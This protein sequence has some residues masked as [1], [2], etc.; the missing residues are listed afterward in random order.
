MK[1]VEF[2]M[3]SILDRFKKSWNAF[4]GRDPTDGMSLYDLGP[5]T[6]YRPDRTRFYTL[7]VNRSIVSTI[8]NRIAV[9]CSMINI[10]HVK[11]NDEG[12]YQ[13]TINSTLN[14]CLTMNANIDQ[15]GRMF[16]QDAIMSMFDEGCVA[17]TPINTS[18]NPRN[19]ES[20]KIYDLRVGKIVEWYPKDVRIRVYNE[21]T[22]Q[23]EEKI[24]PKSAV[25]IVEN[26][27][28]S[29]MNE[30]NSLAQRLIRTLGQIDRINEQGAA[31]KM[32]IIIQLPYALKGDAKKAQAENRRKLLE[33]QLTNS[34]YGIGYIDQTEKIVQLNRSL[35]N[36][37]WTQAE[38]LRKQLYNQFGLTENIFN[39]TASE[40]E[41]LYYY[42]TTIDPI[43]SALSNA[44]EWKFLSKTAR[45]QG[46]A[47]RYY[48]DPFR[49]VPV[50]ELAEIADKFTRN[51]IMSSN[52][53]RS[54]IGLH[55]SEDPRAD[56]LINA[57]INQSKEDQ[58]AGIEGREPVMDEET[59]EEIQPEA[60][61]NSE[62][63]PLVPEESNQTNELRQ[64]LASLQ[65]YL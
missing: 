59:G 37:L 57:N 23:H 58:R 26:P 34:Q 29:I 56:E 63:Q 13:E 15:T 60:S 51:E 1:G 20:F 25:A 41:Q 24:F 10:Q 4:M 35:E 42:N 5:G 55:P 50:K 62:S 33:A 18:V 19:K 38:D 36:N 43:L 8:Y 17:L 46:Q 11:V 16:I 30:P 27:F 28:Y 40:E 48:R 2:K 22:G 64:I 7:G 21:E 49:L 12:R 65:N 45:S 61:T 31:N 53:F 52:E 14:D 44:M 32:D 47:I 54:I 6:Y 9:D 39:G 3:P